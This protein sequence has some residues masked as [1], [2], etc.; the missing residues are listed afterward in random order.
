MKH[1][2]IIAITALLLTACG[3]GK[4]T[5]TDE[6]TATVVDTTEVESTVATDTTTVDSIH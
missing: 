1:L 5:E 2:A 6:T 4:N 3:K